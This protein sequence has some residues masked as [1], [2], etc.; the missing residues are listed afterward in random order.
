MTGWKPIPLI[1]PKV[2]TRH[3]VR[4]SGATGAKRMGRKR[5]YG[6]VML[7]SRWDRLLACLFSDDR[8]EAYPTDCS[9]DANASRGA[10]GWGDRGEASGPKVNV[11]LRHAS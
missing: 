9:E 5:T 4:W 2:L 8:L 10:L 3:T 7:R 11:R 6:C 1:V